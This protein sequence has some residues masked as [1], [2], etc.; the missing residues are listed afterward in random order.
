VTGD[1]F[2][3]VGLVLRVLKFR[4]ITQFEG[5]PVFPGKPCQEGRVHQGLLFGAVVALQ[6]H[7][8]VEVASFL[9]RRSHIPERGDVIACVFLRRRQHTDQG[10]VISTVSVI[11][12][13]C[14]LYSLLQLVRS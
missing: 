5:E 13:Q 4:V 3:K 9:A 10:D 2:R 11:I 7:M 6:Q 14:V 1:V 12:P 8:D